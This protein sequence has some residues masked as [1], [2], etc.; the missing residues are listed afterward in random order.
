MH[1]MFSS[2]MRSHLKAKGVKRALDMDALAGCEKKKPR[3]SSI[4]GVA[5]P[6]SSC[7]QV[8][9]GHFKGYDL[10]ELPKEAWPQDTTNKGA[11]GYTI[12]AG[13]AAIC[14]SIRFCFVGEVAKQN[15]QL[16][17]QRLFLFQVVQT[18]PR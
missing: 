13:G 12:K 5:P 7:P 1:I 15:I 3:P 14:L 8:V 17:Y 9:D 2:R 11:H 18:L 4:H 10:S 6:S 16:I